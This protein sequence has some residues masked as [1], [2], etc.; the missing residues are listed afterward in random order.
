VGPMLVP[1][2]EHNVIHPGLIAEREFARA[3]HTGGVVIGIPLLYEPTHFANP[4]L[5]PAQI[6]LIDDVPPD[7]GECAES[8]HAITIVTLLVGVA[9]CIRK[10]IDAS[11]L[12]IQRE[13]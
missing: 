6:P 9:R 1:T 8:C 12:Y 4:R 2:L 5:V 7:V 3:V 10:G 13:N 11:I